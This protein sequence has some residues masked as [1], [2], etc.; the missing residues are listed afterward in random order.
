MVL[1]Y[2]YN[3]FG[4]NFRLREKLWLKNLTIGGVWA[5]L[6]FS[7]ED[8]ELSIWHFPAIVFFIFGLLMA[9]DLR[10][11][12][13][14]KI[15]TIPRKFGPKTAKIIGAVSLI[16]SLIFIIFSGISHWP[17]WLLTIFVSLIFIQRADSVKPGYYFSIFGEFLCALPLLFS[18]ALPNF[19]VCF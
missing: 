17:T 5:S 19:T 12:S 8:E 16:F 7:V 3:G 4:L 15:I 6:I 2:F 11:A 1:A 14:D 10:D 13:R 18:L 9:Y